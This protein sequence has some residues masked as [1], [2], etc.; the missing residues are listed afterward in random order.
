MGPAILVCRLWSENGTVTLAAHGNPYRPRQAVHGYSH[1]RHHKTR[2]GGCTEEVLRWFN[3][4]HAS[5]DPGC[6]N[7]RTRVPNHP[8]LSLHPCFVNTSPTMEKSQKADGFIYL[9]LSFLNVC[10]LQCANVVLQVK[11]VVNKATDWCVWN[12]AAVCCGIWSVSN[13]CTVSVD[14]LSI[15]CARI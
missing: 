6:N 4:S 13:N 14:L 12:L 9:S 5:I 3:Y 8:A 1:Q 11:N 7:N 15:H 10:Y 2:V